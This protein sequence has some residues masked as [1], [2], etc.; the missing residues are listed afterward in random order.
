MNSDGIPMLSDFGQIRA[1]QYLV[2]QS[3]TSF[4]YNSGETINWMAPE[5]VE[6]IAESDRPLSDVCTRET[7][8]WAY[9]MVILVSF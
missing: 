6:F 1:R 5:I 4:D 2:S 3:Q 9:G 7:D 8:M